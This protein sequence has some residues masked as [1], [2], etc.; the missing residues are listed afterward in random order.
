MCSFCR[1]RGTQ[2]AVVALDV[3]LGVDF[4]KRRVSAM[5]SE[6]ASGDK[7]ACINCASLSSEVFYEAQLIN[8]RRIDD[9]ALHH[10]ARDALF[11]RVASRCSAA[12]SMFVFVS[13]PRA[14]RRFSSR[15]AF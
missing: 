2:P 9:A 11:A 1:R 13:P 8:C 3:D 4:Q 10:F 7:R 15:L 6:R 14:S 5:V 12:A